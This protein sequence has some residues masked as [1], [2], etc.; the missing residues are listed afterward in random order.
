MSVIKNFMAEILQDPRVGVAVATS[1]T[2]AGSF[3]DYLPDFV[4][5]KIATLLGIFLTVLLICIHA[6][7]LFR[8]IKRTE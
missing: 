3:L 6:I 8:M 5:A 1:T 4:L 2:A 7:K